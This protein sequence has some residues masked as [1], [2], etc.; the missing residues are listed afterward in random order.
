MFTE[1]GRGC[2][3]LMGKFVRDGTQR[4]VHGSIVVNVTFAGML[5]PFTV[6]TL[7]AYLTNLVLPFRPSLKLSQPVRLRIHGLNE[8]WYFQTTYAKTLR[9]H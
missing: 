5:W 7:P 6:V 4:V 9:N 1:P 2:V 3:T 8:G